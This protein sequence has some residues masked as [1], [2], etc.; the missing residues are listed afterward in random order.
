M[1]K[2]S[3]ITRQL[4]KYIALDNFHQ[5]THAQDPSHEGRFAG[6]NSQAAEQGFQF[7]SI[8]LNIR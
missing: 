8:R 1:L 2:L 7:I 4:P 3:E 5:R 6:V